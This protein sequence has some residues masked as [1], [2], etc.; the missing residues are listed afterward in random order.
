MVNRF[1]RVLQRYSD[2][3][4]SQVIITIFWRWRAKSTTRSTC[5]TMSLITGSR[6]GAIRKFSVGS[7]PVPSVCVPFSSTLLLQRHGAVTVQIVSRYRSSSLLLSRLADAAIYASPSDRGG[8]DGI[9]TTDPSNTSAPLMGSLSIF[10]CRAIRPLNKLAALAGSLGYIHPP[11]GNGQ[12]QAQPNS[13][14]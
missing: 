3:V 4:K 2:V 5:C 14:P 13:P 9:S 6:I 1:H 12:R 8:T 7:E 11:A 10:F